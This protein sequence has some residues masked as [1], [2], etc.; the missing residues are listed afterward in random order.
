MGTIER[1]AVT[2]RETWLAMR[3]QDV[4]ASDMGALFGC[5]PW[6]SAL[7][8]YVDK[9]ETV[10]LEQA[11]NSVLRRGRILEDAVARAVSE[12]QP[13]WQIEKAQ[14]YVRDSLNRI[15]CT[16]DFYLLAGERRGVMQTKTVARDAFRKSWGD[17]P[18]PYVVLQNATEMMLLGLDW[19]V[20]AA[21]VVDPYKLDIHIYQLT[22][23]AAL[24]QTIRRNVAKFWET[25]DAREMPNVDFERDEAQ[26]AA[27]YPQEEVGKVADLSGDNMLP[28]LL[29]EREDLT[30]MIKTAEVR[31]MV[32][33]NEIKAKM[34]DAERGVVDDWKITWKMRAGYTAEVK[35]SR[36]LRVKRMR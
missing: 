26:L 33:D 15:G 13:T 34:Q 9:T 35:P 14:E 2:D 4:T 31:R 6:R 11:D 3:K 30:A 10:S 19:G 8:L 28:Q 18:P 27:L 7:A 1:H 23:N 12:E 29:V 25:T 22:R 21:L 36:V 5:H 24:E 17:L 20:I 16:P 32:I